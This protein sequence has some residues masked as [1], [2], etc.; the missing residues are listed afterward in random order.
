M[1]E[2]INSIIYKLFLFASIIVLVFAVIE[3]SRIENNIFKVDEIIISGCN[4]IKEESLEK[5]FSYLINKNIY[6]LNSNDIEAKI[7]ENEF[8]SSVNIIKVYPRT[9][10]LDII[11]ISP[12][13]IFKSNN[14]NFLVDNNNNG[15]LCSSSMSN[16]IHAPELQ[17]DGRLNLKNIFNSNEYRI[18]HHIHNN[19]PELFSVIKNIRSNNNNIIIATTMNSWI[20]FNK[21]HYIEQAKHIFN[22]LNEMKGYDNYEYIKFS[23]LDVIVKERKEI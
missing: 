16:S 6:S 19:D 2:N 18:L 17:S 20:S 21:N 22:F 4:L 3:S 1:K 5:Q 11:E 23:H 8:I 12:I 15:F 14:T 10:I 7:L 9:I 13:G